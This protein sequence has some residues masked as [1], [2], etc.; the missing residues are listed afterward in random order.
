MT[1]PFRRRHHDAEAGHDRA[2]MLM[3]EGLLVQLTP[4]DAAWLGRHLD[5]CAECGRDWKAFRADRKL[6]RTLRSQPPEPPR[7]LW[8]KTSAALDREARRRGGPAGQRTAGRSAGLR[9]LPLGAIASVAVLAVVIGTT[10]WPRPSL[11]PTATAQGTLPVA[12][13]PTPAPTGLLLP[14]AEPVAIFRQTAAGSWELVY[15]DVTE[16]CPQ[17]NKSCAPKPRGEAQ[18]VEIAEAPSQIALSGDRLAI[19]SEPTAGGRGMVL[20]VEVDKP[21]ESPAPSEPASQP[22]IGPSAS[23][24]STPPGSIAIATGVT[25]VGDVS[26]SADGRWLAFSARPDDGSTGPDLYLWEV[27]Q[28]VA[29]A[30]TSDHQTYFSSWH[31]GRILASRVESASVPGP[32]A[33]PQPAASGEPS[34]TAE[35]GR[36]NGNANGGGNGGGRPRASEA[37]SAA[38]ATATPGGS[39]VPG[40]SEPP[41]IVEGHPVSFLLDP[42]TLVRTDLTN[43]DIWLP[44][45]GPNGR[46][47]AYWSGTLTSSDGRTWSLGAG[48]LVLD[49]WSSEGDPT[50]PPPSGSPEATDAGSGEPG[51]SASPTIEPSPPVLGPVGLRTVL[52]PGMKAAFEASFDPAGERLAIWIGEDLEEKVGR[53]HLLVLDPESGTIS[54]D[55]PLQGA[56]ALRRF[57]IDS[58]RLAW[59]TPNGQDGQES[60]VQVLGWTD[61]GFGEIESE[62][63]SDLYLP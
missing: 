4:D 54:E 59:V 13:V 7:D 29:T 39:E 6:L 20:V 5:G 58:G 53:L 30:V 55:S 23:P 27:G 12:V 57:V 33:S 24:G 19:A 40:S 61:D 60:A 28:P 17:S 35:P 36:G 52:V 31:D 51:A 45:I 11:P 46:F 8:A 26:Y 34:P 56:T 16:V 21:G 62:P 32:G 2:R 47:V 37:P 49:Q 43:P 10:L 63:G 48:E 44:V 22:P 18:P 14:D 3:S 9:A 25:V 41:T 38:P 15:S 42:A 1:L 50:Q